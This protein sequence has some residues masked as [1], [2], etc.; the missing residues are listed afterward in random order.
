MTKKELE[1][2]NCILLR[3]IS[4]YINYFKVQSGGKEETIAFQKGR[5][6]FIPANLDQILYFLDEI[7][8]YYN[9][10]GISIHSLK[11]L[12]AGCGI[13]NIL[14]IANLMGFNAYGIEIDSRNIRIA[15]KLVT[16]SY[17]IRFEI[18]KGDILTFKNYSHYDVIYFYYPLYDYEK[19]KRFEAKLVNDMKVGAI[20]MQYGSKDALKNDSRFKHINKKKGPIWVKTKE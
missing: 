2:R 19:Q 6:Q 11:F 1:R 12:D 8:E 9:K 3:Y 4:S 20:V 15:K 13:G 5:F 18:T 14:M 16:N 17:R 10:K 7:V